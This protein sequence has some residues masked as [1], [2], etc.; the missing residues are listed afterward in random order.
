MKSYPYELTVKTEQ[1]FWYGANGIF[2]CIGCND[3][4]K[5]YTEKKTKKKH[6]ITFLEENTFQS[7]A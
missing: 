7:L 6:N 1:N 5:P 4:S 3:L 2:K